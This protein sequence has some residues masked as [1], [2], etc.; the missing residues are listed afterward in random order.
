M[1]SSFP[2]H[3]AT[4]AFLPALLFALSACSSESPVEVDQSLAANGS[5]T[6]G[7][8]AGNTTTTATRASACNGTL[9]AVTVSQ[10]SVPAGAS[11]TLNGTRVRGD[12]KVARGGTVSA[13]GARIEGNLQAE[14]ARAVNTSA[15]TVVIGDIQIKR[16]A[17]ATIANTS[18]TGN[19]QIE[20]GGASLIASAT[21]VGGNVQVSKAESAALTGLTVTG[22][23]QFEENRGALRSTGATVR[24]NF[25][26]VK[27]LGGVELRNNRV[28]QVLECKENVPAPI[29]SGNV[30]GEKKEQC[31]AL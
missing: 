18:I 13:I 30:A 27:N 23:I 31:R 21:Q 25:Q 20:E 5:T 4:A 14:D 11:C 6:V 8:T 9:G 28:S 26:V 2:R 3:A 15:N 29:G 17:V 10:V 7:A 19:L 22:D 12:V 24:G 16:L 1:L